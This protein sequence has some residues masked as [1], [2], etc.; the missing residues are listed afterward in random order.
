[1]VDKVE[2]VSE[3]YGL[4]NDTQKTKVMVATKE[5]PNVEF[6]CDD[7]EREQV[8][9]FKHL[10]ATISGTCDGSKEIMAGLDIT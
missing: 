6:T 3:Q 5:K 9:S 8:E 7:E 10:E 1:L 4:E 2:Y